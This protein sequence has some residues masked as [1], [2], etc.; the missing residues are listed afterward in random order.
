VL[1]AG[2]VVEAGP[3]DAVF[4]SIVPEVE[5]LLAGRRRGP[6]GLHDNRSGRD[7]RP[8]GPRP[9]QSPFDIPLWLAALVLLVAIAAIL[10]LESILGD[11]R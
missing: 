11:G 10:W 2:R 3:V 8:I 7:P 4:T 9:D 1:N 6:I 5:Q